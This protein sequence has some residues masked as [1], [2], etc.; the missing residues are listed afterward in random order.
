MLVAGTDLNAHGFGEPLDD[1]EER[2]S[3][4]H[5]SLVRLR[6]DE[7]AHVAVG[8][9]KLKGFV[10]TILVNREGEVVKCSTCCTSLSRVTHSRRTASGRQ[11]KQLFQCLNC[12]VMK[13]CFK[14]NY[15]SLKK[16][17]AVD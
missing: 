14:T 8:W 13:P 5:G 6:V 10:R 11:Y 9:S 2:V 12:V 17:I 15:L 4:Q 16:L 7:F 3:G 1:G